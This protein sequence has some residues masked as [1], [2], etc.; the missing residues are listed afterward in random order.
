MYN[1]ILGTLLSSN[2]SN[3]TNSTN[4]NFVLWVRCSNNITTTTTTTTAG[5]KGLGKVRS[6]RTDYLAINTPYKQVF[7]GHFIY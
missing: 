2:T 1:V 4:T 5:N 3:T 6:V 7:G